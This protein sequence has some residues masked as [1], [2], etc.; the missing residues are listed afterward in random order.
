[1]SKQRIT[2][3]AGRHGQNLL[4]AS[5]Q[6][7]GQATLLVLITILGW[8]PREAAAQPPRARN[9]VYVESNDPAGNAIFA[10]ARNDANGSLMPLPGSPFPAGGLG[11]TFTTA[12]GPFDSDQEVIV[13]PQHTLLFAVNGGSDT[14]AVFNIQADGSLTPVAGSPFPSGAP[15][16]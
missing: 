2:A 11:I 5:L 6:A 3:A 15:I 7:T 9:F 1:M 10:F 4:R 16:P 14:I 12:L 8:A 13:N